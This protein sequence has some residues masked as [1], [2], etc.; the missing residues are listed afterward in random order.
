MQRIDHLVE[1]EVGC[2]KKRKNKSQTDKSTRQTL[3]QRHPHLHTDQYNLAVGES[4]NEM[5]EPI[6]RRYS[7]LLR[8]PDYLTQVL[9]RGAD[10]ARATAAQTWAQVQQAIGFRLAR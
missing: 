4:V 9:D 10:K 7:E 8:H 1:V 6:R 5:L 3:G 2:K